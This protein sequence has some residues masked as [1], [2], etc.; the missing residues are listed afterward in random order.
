MRKMKVL[1]VCIGNACRSQM[2]QA[3]ARTYGSDVIEPE[4]AGLAPATRIPEVTERIMA[5]KGIQLAGQFPKSVDEV[6][7]HDIDLVV[8][9]SGRALRGLPVTR[10]RDWRVK[11]PIGEKEQVHKQVRDEIERF[12]MSLVLELRNLKSSWP[13]R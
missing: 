3:F 10:V 5:E 9:L 8:N 12:V 2:A 6:A 4:S 11:D 1:F 13:A 7:L